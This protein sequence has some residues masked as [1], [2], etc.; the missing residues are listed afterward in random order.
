MRHGTT[1]MIPEVALAVA[2]PMAATPLALWVITRHSRV[3]RTQDTRYL[4][5]RVA[6]P[7]DKIPKSS[8]YWRLP[9]TLTFCFS[10]AIDGFCLLFPLQF[11]IMATN[12]LTTCCFYM[13]VYIWADS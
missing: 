8:C 13:V 9:M 2:A 12:D 7:L 6:P 5:L 10:F 3:E 11:Y 1:L 4:S